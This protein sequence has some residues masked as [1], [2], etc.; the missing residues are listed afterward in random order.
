MRMMTTGAIAPPP[1]PTIPCWRCGCNCCTAW[2][3]QPACLRN[4]SA[5]SR[6]PRD[7]WRSCV[8]VGSGVYHISRRNHVALL[9]DN[10]EVYAA[11]KDVARAQFRLDD[12]AAA[13]TEP[14]PSNS[15]PLSSASSGTVA[16]NA[17]VLRCRRPVPPFI[18]T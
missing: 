4:G 16:P 15:R 6:S 14:E 2:R 10:I 3:L 9:M 1:M 5:A 17:F 18:P 12:P 7:N 11:L 13:A 8:T